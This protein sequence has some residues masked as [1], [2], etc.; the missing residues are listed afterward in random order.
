MIM[1]IISILILI[2]LLVYSLNML[3]KSIRR[4]KEIQ[5]KK[6]K[7][8]SYFSNQETNVDK[9]IEKSSRSA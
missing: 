8:E 7:A 3:R 4:N 9:K 5:E 2:C 6:K 1:G